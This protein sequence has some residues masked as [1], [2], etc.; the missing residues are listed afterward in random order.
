MAYQNKVTKISIKGYKSIKSLESFE[1]A[2]LNVMIGSNGAGKSNFIS[3][4][5]FLSEIAQGGLQSLIRKSGGANTLLYFGAKNTTAIEVKIEFGPN[6]YWLKLIPT[7]DDS[8]YFEEEG[9]P[10][11]VRNTLN[12]L[13]LARFHLTEKKPDYPNKSVRLLKVFWK[14]LVVGNYS[15]STI[16][17]TRL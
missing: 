16:L 3:L 17:A 6:S 8:L 11:K 13:H 2:D 15:T 5:K 4:F 12:P 1:L 10:I 14:A 9:D 7:A